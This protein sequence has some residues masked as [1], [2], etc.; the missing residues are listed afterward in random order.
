MRFEPFRPGH[1]AFIKPQPEQRIEHAQM[2]QVMGD[3]VFDTGTALSAWE[4]SVCIAAAGVI[5]V[6]RY[7]AS[8]WALL[9]ERAAPHMLPIVRRMRAVMNALPY[10]RYDITVREDFDQGHRFAKLL[11]AVCETPKPMRYYGYGGAHEIMYA[12]VKD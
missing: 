9:S 4:D 1:L 8:A 5:P 12:Y 2:L 6:H 10:M 3:E 7:R 11:G